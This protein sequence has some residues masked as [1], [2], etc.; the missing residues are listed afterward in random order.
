MFKGTFISEKFKVTSQSIFSIAF[1]VILQSMSL[2][3]MTFINSAFVGHYNIK[4]LSAINNVMFPFM[5][6]FTLLIALSQGTTVLIAQA[7]GAKD[8]AGAKKIAESSMFYT[9]IISFGYCFFWL[10]CGKIVLIIMGVSNEI[11]ESGLKAAYCITP[12]ENS[13]E[14]AMANAVKNLCMAAARLAQDIQNL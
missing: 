9:Q 13:F 7:I 4:G 11:L 2:Y 10:F 6:L 3:I 12:P 1:P 14:E 5:M 8:I